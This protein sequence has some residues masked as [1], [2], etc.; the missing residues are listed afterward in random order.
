MVVNKFAMNSIIITVY[1]R[2]HI[3]FDIYTQFTIELSTLMGYL[4]L[5]V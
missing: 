3:I 5:R 2:I 4:Y 1:S